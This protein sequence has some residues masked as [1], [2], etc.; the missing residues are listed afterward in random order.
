MTQQKDKPAYEPRDPYFFAYAW[1]VI[2][3]ALVPPTSLDN[4]DHRFAEETGHACA[5]VLD[6]GGAPPKFLSRHAVRRIGEI[7]ELKALTEAQV[8]RITT[9]RPVRI[10]TEGE[11]QQALAR[12]A[13][14][15]RELGYA[16]P[17]EQEVRDENAADLDRSQDLSELVR[18]AA[19]HA[20]SVRLSATSDITGA[21]PDEAIGIVLEEIDRAIRIHA[22]IGLPVTAIRDDATVEDSL[23]G[24]PYPAGIAVAVILGASEEPELAAEQSPPTVK[25]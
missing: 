18:L 21:R 10:G 20:A 13:E 12:V 14:R 2:T 9:A 23:R 6:G 25:G 17:T 22:R 15:E 11:K 7:R 3:A 1:S 5:V 8:D 19:L 24:L 16:L 4:S